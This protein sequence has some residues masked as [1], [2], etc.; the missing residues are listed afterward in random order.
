MKKKSLRWG[1]ELIDPLSQTSSLCS[2]YFFFNFKKYLKLNLNMM[3][4]LNKK[5]QLRLTTLIR[6]DIHLSLFQFRIIRIVVV[7]E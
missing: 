7:T 1:I 5:Q 6:I 4:K 2:H 3:I